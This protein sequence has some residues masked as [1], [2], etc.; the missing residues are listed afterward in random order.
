MAAMEVQWVARHLS[1]GERLGEILFGL[2]MT[3][4]FTLG[5]GVLFGGGEEGAAADM[6]LGI[7]GCNVAWGII[8]AAMLIL[9]RVFDRG[10]AVRLGNAIRQTDSD[11]GAIAAVAAEFDET[12]AAITSPAVR[13]T[14]YRDVLTRVREREPERTGVRADD[15]IAAFAVF[16]LV[17]FASLPAAL[18]FLVIEDYWIAL[19]VSNV[20]L[21]GL[22][23]LV[24]YHWAGYTSI[25]RWRAGIVLTILGIALVAVAIPLGG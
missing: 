23:F 17:V 10:R 16:W 21:I 25:D 20:L 22:S 7:V 9:G 12:L 11:D 13:A 1:P 5:A 14:L 15:W 24:G 3:L 2:L 4:T 18:P 19:R 8:D 6:L